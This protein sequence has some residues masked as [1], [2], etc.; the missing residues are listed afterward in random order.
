MS[1]RLHDGLK[2]AKK[3]LDNLNK[4]MPKKMQKECSV[5][6]YSNC[7]E[8]GYNIKYWKDI[9][10]T[11]PN[12]ITLEVSFAENRNSDNIVVYAGRNF[13]LQGNIPSE[14]AYT[15]QKLFEPDEYDKAAEFILNYFQTTK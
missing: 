3:V 10:E 11:K 6:A 9:S 13:S 12:F 7:R 14:E 1:I 2:V 5:E 15:N 8:Q 4:I